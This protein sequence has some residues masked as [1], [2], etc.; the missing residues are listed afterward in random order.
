[1]RSVQKS[2]VS[3]GL[4]HTA[5]SAHLPSPSSAEDAAFDAGETPHYWSDAELDILAEGVREGLRNTAIASRLKKAGFERSLNAV[6]QRAACI[7]QPRSY[8]TDEEISFLKKHYRPHDT[9]RSSEEIAA[10]IGR[11]ASAVRSMAARMQMPTTARRRWDEDER[12][13]VAVEATIPAWST[14]AAIV[15]AG[16][17]T[18]TARS[19]SRARV[20]HRFP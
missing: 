3:T 7:R 12:A 5:M 1:M 2:S 8:W 16:G 20:R 4:A 18:G 15:L 14:R 10:K 13:R 9:T 19:R 6:R 11:S 17:T